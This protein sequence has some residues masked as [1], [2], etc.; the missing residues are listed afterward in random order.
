MA[1]EYRQAK[2]HDLAAIVPLVEGFAREQ[3]EQMPVN[4]LTETFMEFARSGIAQAIQHPAACVMVAEETSGEKPVI[5]GYAV[6]MIQE[7]PPIFEPEMYTFISDL[8][9]QPEF[10][11]QGLATALVER[12]R[13]WGWVKGITR[14]SLVLPTNCPAQGLYAK[15]GF[16]SVQTMLYYRDDA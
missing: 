7:P 14:L 11:R 8:Y 3:Q 9:V 13:G 2:P 10:R 4:T 12:V 6:G 5:V 1:I 16:K 15:L